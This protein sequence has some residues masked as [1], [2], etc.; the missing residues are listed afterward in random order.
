MPTTVHNIGL[1]PWVTVQCTLPHSQPLDEDGEE[2]AVYRR[3]NGAAQ[4]VLQAHPD[5][6]MPYGKVPRMI[7]A[8][9]VVEYR[10]QLATM[11]PLEARRLYLGRSYDSFL[12]KLGMFRAGG[13]RGDLTRFKRQAMRLFSCSITSVWAP[14]RPTNP[15]RLRRHDVASEAKV[16]WDTDQPA[17]DAIQDSYVCLS[18][19]FAAACD[20][21]VPVDMD[22]MRALRSPFQLDLYAW[23]SYRAGRLHL[24]GHPPAQIPWTALLQ[25]FGHSYKRPRAF[26][27]AF[28]RNLVRV[29]ER[30]PVSVDCDG[31]SEG[32]VVEP[33]APDIPWSAHGA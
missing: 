13:P 25:Q 23:L 11:P 12:R 31:W 8:Q 7:L 33:K 26:R 17:L 30:Y 16:W 21:A 27:D 4:L 2:L 19:P 22:T 3:T 6:G 14:T 1:L 28:K 9:L 15:K 5:H 24:D 10:R 29:Q 20:H 32:I 18:E